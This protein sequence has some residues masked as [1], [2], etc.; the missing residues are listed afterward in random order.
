MR[1][2]SSVH[3]VSRALRILAAFIDEGDELSVAQIASLLEVHKST[4][5][6]LAATLVTH[7]F[8]ERTGDGERLRL[9]EEVA[10]LGLLAVR[11]R[12]L[13]D[14]AQPVMDELARQTKET[15]VLSVPRGNRGLDVAEAGPRRLVR[16]T[17]WIGRSSPLHA[18]SDGKIFLA[19]GAASLGEAAALEVVTAAT[20]T[21]ARRLEGELAV[22]R[23]R[24]WAT[25][26]GELEEGLNGVAGAIIDDA[27]E[28]IASLS[29]SGPAYRVSPDRLDDL[30]GRCLA[31]AR[32]ISERVAMRSQA[33]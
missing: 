29:V 2:Q 14:V 28:C 32:A 30:A 10:R 31:A 17:T 12:S 1:N 11:N 21:D 19:F 8:L 26:V 5:S 3:T 4:A 15:V 7:G 27:G 25:A 18:C 22:V 23:R 24:G 9:G 33:A 13:I 20:I 16:A 6:R